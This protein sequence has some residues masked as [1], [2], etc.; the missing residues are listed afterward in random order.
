MQVYYVG[1][2]TRNNHFNRTSPNGEQIFKT[3]TCSL[4]FILLANVQDAQSTSTYYNHLFS[5]LSHFFN[6]NRKQKIKLKI[7]AR[8][9]K[10]QGVF[11][12]RFFLNQSLNDDIF[13]LTICIAFS[14]SNIAVCTQFTLKI[15]FT[16]SFAKTY[17][18]LISL[19]PKPLNL[20]INV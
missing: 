10:R 4:A 16:V 6:S 11:Y 13:I 1:T 7:S 19:L 8:K 5:L 18:M 17:F 14:L 2:K 12:E 20:K 3:K 9:V 15:Q